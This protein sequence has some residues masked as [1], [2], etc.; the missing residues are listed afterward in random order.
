MQ[1]KFAS[2]WPVAVVV[3]V[4]SVAEPVGIDSV[5][6]GGVAVGARVVAVAGDAGVDVEVEAVVVDVAAA[7]AA[8]VLRLCP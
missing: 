1:E 4:A 6:A 3:A 8:A 2:S 5:A 7:I